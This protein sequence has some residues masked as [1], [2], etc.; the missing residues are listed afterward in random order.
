MKNIC[1]DSG[2]LEIAV[3][4]ATAAD[5][6]MIL[7]FIRKKAEFDKVPHRVEADEGKLREEL[8]GEHPA[9]FVIF[10]EYRGEPIGFALYFLTFSSF[11]CRK[12]IWL[13]DLY[14]DEVHR[15]RGAGRALLYYLARLA[16]DCGYGV[17]EWTAGVSNEKG[18]KFYA[19]NGAI[20]RES[21]RILRLDR[22]RIAVLA[23]KG[24]EQIR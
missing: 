3:R 12:G 15:G 23:E 10:A 17:I 16:S 1:M 2:D 21:V 13:D 9:A 19:E 4:I 20:L 11:I 8:F 22:A 24:K 5:I 7:G 6:P 18:L 14:V